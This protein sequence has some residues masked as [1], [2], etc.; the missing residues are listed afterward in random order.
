M[1][2][3]PFLE[4][5]EKKWLA[6]QLLSALR[7]CHARDVFHGD[8]K[9]ENT[10]VTSWNWLYLTDFSSSF[11]P[12]TLPED[13]PADFSYFFDT[14]GRRTC[15]L[16]PER[17]LAP[18][19]EPDPNARLTWAMDVFSAGCVI[20]ELFLETPIFNLSQLYKYKKG[21]YDPTTAIN[22]IA[23]KDTRELVG[24]MIQLDPERR[25]SAEE[26]LDFWRNKAFP[27][28][29]Y[30]FLH[31]YMALV[32]DPSSGRA[33]I[34]GAT[35]NLGEADDRID[36]IYYDLDK[37]S[38]FL[39]YSND[40]LDDRKPATSQLH[41]QLLPI[42]L[43][44]PNNDHQVSNLNRRPEDDGSLIFLTV[45][46]AAI[47]S[48]A[49]AT[50]RVRGCDLLLAFSERLT[51]EAKLDRVL[52]FVV[53]LL[54]DK[55]DIVKIAAIP[56]LTQIMALVKVISP[57]NSHV[58]QEYIVDRMA[59]F[60]DNQKTKPSPIVR[61][62]YAACI[63]SLASTASRFLD[64]VAT[65]R[66]D[67]S[68][69]TVDPEAEELDQ[70]PA[71]Y[72]L[73]DNARAELIETFEKHTKSLIT[74]A[75]P[76]VRQAF[77][78]SVPDLCMFF[79]TTDANDII[80]SHLN[81][82]LNGR[83]WE[84]KCAFFETG[85]GVATFLGGVSLEEFILPLM[86]Q[87]LTD[88]E[89]F[90]VEKV[91]R[92]LGHMS[93]LGLFQRS[94]IWELVDIVGRFT[95]HPNLWIRQAAAMFI[96]SATIY[97]SLADIQTII[98]P[99][100]R[101]YLK[102]DTRDF[103]ELKL[104]D[105]LKG[106]LPRPIFEL[107]TLWATKSDRGIF[108]KAAR[109]QK[110][111]D[112]GTNN[113][114][115][116]SVSSKDKTQHA[117]S[118][119]PKNEEDEQW[120]AKLRAQGMTSED[121]FKLL[122][123]RVYI[124]RMSHLKPKELAQVP[125]YLNGIVQLKTLGVTPHTVIFDE[126]Y[127]DQPN[128]SR[129]PAEA[130]KKRHSAISE[131]L[132]D[133]SM[134]INDTSA[135]RRQT[136]YSNHQAR[137]DTHISNASELE[138]EGNDQIDA[139]TLSPPTN[140]GDRAQSRLQNTLAAHKGVGV[141]DDTASVASS[142]RASRTQPSAM[143]L[144]KKDTGKSLPQTG[145]TTTT[146]L[147][148]VEGPLKTTGARP[149]A[150]VMA[151]K[152]EEAKKSDGKQ[153]AAHTYSGN[154]PS[155]LHML[156]AM[157][158]EIYPDTQLEFG[159]MV[160][161]LSRRKPMVRG[162]AQDV[163][164]AWHP[165]G[166]LVAQFAEH[167]GPINRIAVAP[168]H[169]F[170]V[171]AGEDGQVKVWDTGRL[172]R[173]V[174]N[175]SR[176]THKHAPGARGLSVCFVENTHCFVSCGSDGT[177]EVVK[178]D[179]TYNSGVA[180]ARYGK[181]KIIR[182]FQLPKDESAVWCEHFRHNTNSV[183]MLATNKSR[184]IALDLRTMAPL[185]VLENPVHHGSPTCFFV[186][187]KKNWLLVGTSQGILDLWDLR[188]K[189]LIRS[190]GVPGASSSI[191]RITLHPFK[192]RGKWV[193]VSGGNEFGEITVWDLEK[194]Q[195]KEVYRTSGSGDEKYPRNYNPSPVQEDRQENLMDRFASA[196]DTANARTP[197]RGILGMVAGTDAFDDGVDLKYGYLITGGSD[198]KIRFWDVAEPKR[199]FVVSGGKADE[200]Q[201][202]LTISQPTPSITLVT[203]RVP[204]PEPSASNAAAGRS[205]SGQSTRSAEKKSSKSTVM[206][207]NQQLMRRTH[208]DAIT[209]IALLESPYGLIVSVDRSGC[210]YVFQ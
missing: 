25:Y 73:Y 120:I 34:S 90:V 67:G 7:D 45:V 191:H 139:A 121:E 22:R 112:F 86:V 30:S 103:S 193:C 68:L 5:I 13:N 172:E 198:R 21:E 160:T 117:F 157:Y 84:L 51:D 59:P 111:F 80:L 52:P 171:T 9:T 154:D 74:D 20:A 109:Q 36:R 43:N 37:I 72:G 153:K 119:V 2:T 141:D 101:S 57:V 42:H 113:H 129:T 168:D 107:A 65:L 6:F 115:I 88:P 192:G 55:S 31:Q 53:S 47:R 183:L 180:A 40:K 177:I 77:L 100:V 62:T 93:K 207:L 35:V 199:S 155:I 102:S 106:P 140:A 182:D 97:L 200:Q 92:S 27:D 149:S 118:K 10:L 142:G 50:A 205:T 197:D 138:N 96:S 165:A 137:L 152:R 87:A 23:D 143:L 148:R 134:T 127:K 190:W 66:A 132:V 95:M 105:T 167:V 166:V 204:R 203:E 170:F 210:T 70:Q 4:D 83:D 12:A 186:D 135:R 161:P 108:W 79:G 39:G 150:L 173:N 206:S 126:T 136:G 189:I 195:C 69:P 3:R 169:A 89:E 188:F 116:A 147:G 176:Q 18:G 146:V 64:M 32:T 48:T 61:A 181:L 98:L 194:F 82:Y 114:A 15:Y 187:K 163:S 202:S 14:A 46:V 158:V 24:N 159:P 76:S 44:I 99:L 33:P 85:V 122:V 26:Y 58:F 1:S 81:T 11:K 128:G 179:V 94:K 131:A 16:A 56:T 185:Y 124:W 145:T 196:H 75:D 156:D 144:T 123:L 208:V 38:Y 164:K 174:A 78:G 63:G 91:L 151:Q 175:R 60:L 29:F 110:T 17:F 41:L 162:S 125:T 19:E 133:A 184:I 49:R 54:N 71:A 130:P 201:P 178:V 28:Y 104:L 209:D 8:I